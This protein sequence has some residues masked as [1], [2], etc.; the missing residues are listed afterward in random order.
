MT[1]Q[2]RSEQRREQPHARPADPNCDRPEAGPG[3]GDSNS[4][5]G[6]A[7]GIPDAETGMRTGDLTNRGDP[8]QD[9]ERLFGE[10]EGIPPQ[11]DND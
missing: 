8:D 1:R 11:E 4:G 6:N 9:R 10:E 5:G 7:A 3:A 2:Q